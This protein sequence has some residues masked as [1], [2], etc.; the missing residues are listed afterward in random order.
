MPT[1][2]NREIEAKYRV[3]VPAVADQMASVSVLSAGFTA[4][5][6]ETETNLDVYY[7]TASYDL[8]RRGL[9][10]RIRQV[11]RGMQIS[12]K[13]LDVRQESAVHHRMQLENWVEPGFVKPPYLAQCSGDLQSLI[14]ERNP[15]DK[16]LRPVLSLYQTRIKRV[17]F[18]DGGGP[19]DGEKHA[20]AELSLDDVRV[21]SGRPPQAIVMDFDAQDSISTFRELELELLPDGEYKQLRLLAGR[22]ARRR[23]LE[24]SRVSK[25]EAGLTALSDFSGDTA[26]PNIRPDM[27]MA[28][29][30]RLIWR[31]QTMQI[32]LLEHGVRAGDDPEFVHDMRVA[33]RRARTAYELFGQ[34]FRQRDV[35][36][37]FTG[38]RRLAKLLG[39][40]RDLDVALVNLNAF[41]QETPR[42]KKADVRKLEELTRDRRTSARAQ[43][44]EW[45]D[46]PEHASLIAGFMK[47]TSSEG[48]GVK[49]SL[50]DSCLPQPIQVRHS[51]PVFILERF[52]RVRVY[53]SLIESS[54]D[55]SADQLHA[56]HIEC[57]YLRYVLEFNRHLL[58]DEGDALIQQLKVI[59]DHLGDLNDCAVEYRRLGKQEQRGPDDG[60]VQRR[61]QHLSETAARLQQEFPA[62][63]REF[64][65][66]ENRRLLGASIANI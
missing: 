46:S 33:I 52:E 14:R 6:A 60:I 34:Y 10:L 26:K 56:L 15:R 36:P 47:F 16:K 35:K 21:M 19:S 55:V 3:L 9:A 13:T 7:D 30:C 28:E 43:L 64:V 39:R 61:M 49:K 38:L 18:H 24:N 53:E 20:L 48:K 8:L 17:I 23:G 4:G 32:V 42:S 44:M 66:L 51:M 59:Q 2:S 11:E 29:A 57:K 25:L 54:A 50:S 45:L 27:H 31:R 63:F 22:L 5:A 58:G 65:T 1:S 12:A 62:R 40:V 41:H 37:Y